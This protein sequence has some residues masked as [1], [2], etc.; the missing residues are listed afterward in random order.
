MMNKYSFQHSKLIFYERVKLLHEH[1]LVSL[2]IAFLCCS[3]IFFTLYDVSN[4]TWL[5]TWYVFAIAVFIT[6]FCF[7]LLFKMSPHRSQFNLTLFII[8]T[9]LTACIW[10]LAGTVLMPPHEV[11]QQAVVI[12]VI[13]GVTAGSIQSIQADRLASSLYVVLSILPLD[14]WIFMQG[15]KPYYL[16][17]TAVFLYMIFMLVFSKRGYDLILSTFK[18]RYENTA[19]NAQL[20]EINKLLNQEIIKHQENEKTLAQFA[21]IVQHSKDAIISLDVYGSIQT[22]NKGAEALYGFTD[23]EMKNR[24]MAMITPENQLDLLNSMLQ[25][26]KQNISYQSVEL[27]RK[28]KTG[29]LIPVSITLSPI[30]NPAGN[31]IGI[32][33]M[34]RDISER[35]EIDKVKNE[36]IS[37]VSH[38]LRTPLTSIKGSVALL[39]HEVKQN[40][41]RK[42]YHLLEIAYANCER[43]IN[44]INDI[45]D[46]E[47]IE[48]GNMAFHFAKIN[49]RHLIHDAIRQNEILTEKLGIKLSIVNEQ[50]AIIRAD[51]DKLMQVM[52]N[53]LSN[54]IKFS[55]QNGSIE[56]KMQKKTEGITI[57]VTDHGP[58]IAEDF[59]S[60]IFDKFTQ[61][62]TSASRNKGGTGL[63]LS[64]C[65]AILE[66]HGTTIKFT[67]EKNIGTTF[68][69][70]LPLEENIKIKEKNSKSSPTHED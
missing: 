33:S 60:K 8:G 13:A 3:I 45:L 16:M 58:G 50:D 23:A 49:L 37:I 21:E 67:S 38:E 46:I 56:I 39:M 12:V 32:S 69:F 66:K 2:P 36:F 6:R 64:I 41:S 43:L 34:D 30:K 9:T 10:S 61:A 1:L 26:I 47:K 25:K 44:L 28:H 70:D 4:T 35:K 52:T 19:I 29:Y 55:N 22:W 53:L 42:E 5:I 27:T 48:S 51:Y 31:I 15:S 17:G 54:A 57:G 14:S 20:A 63:G 62:D 11:L 65:K 59:K 24:T 68:Y 7:Y 18:L 40:H